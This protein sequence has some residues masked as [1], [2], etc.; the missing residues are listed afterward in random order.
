MVTIAAGKQI[1]AAS[2]ERRG[3]KIVHLDDDIV[4]VDKAAGLL[5]M[6]SEAEKERTAHRILN[7]HLKALTGS[8]SQQAFIVHRLDRRPRA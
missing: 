1:P 5:S 3:L 7:D 8:P 4:V 6:G 2:I